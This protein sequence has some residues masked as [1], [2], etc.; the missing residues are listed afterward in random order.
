MTSYLVYSTVA[1]KWNRKIQSG[2]TC[3]RISFPLYL[4][5]ERHS[6]P[7]FCNTPLPA[8]N[9]FWKKV[10]LSTKSDAFYRPLFCCL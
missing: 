5:W 6:T 1:L 3:R 4:V 8:S 9:N 10:Q 2:N 7:L